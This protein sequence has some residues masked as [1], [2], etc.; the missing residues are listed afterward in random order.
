MIAIRLPI[1][2]PC[3]MLASSIPG[4]GAPGKFAFPRGGSARLR[5]SA[6]RKRRKCLPRKRRRSWRQVPTAP[7]ACCRWPP[8]PP[9]PWSWS[10]IACTVSRP[11]LRAAVAGRS[12]RSMWFQLARWQ[13]HRLRPAAIRVEARHWAAAQQFV[14]GGAGP[15]RRVV[16]LYPASVRPARESHCARR[17]STGQDVQGPLSAASLELVGH[18]EERGHSDPTHDH[19][20][21]AGAVGDREGAARHGSGDDAGANEPW[22]RKRRNTW[23]RS[24]NYGQSSL[25]DLAGSGLAPATQARRAIPSRGEAGQRP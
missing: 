13:S 22:A 12:A 1:D 14:P 7:P 11:R 20:V 5:A 17:L 19:D 10:C 2:R 3:L 16:N 6:A 15:L 4:R 21:P 18:G 8:L 24:R 25:G 9:R 23:R